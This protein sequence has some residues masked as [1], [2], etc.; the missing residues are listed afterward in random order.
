MCPLE[1]TA[2][3]WNSILEK[4]VELRHMLGPISEDRWKYTKNLL[5]YISPGL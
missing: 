5:K 1:I 4:K 2:G 3:P